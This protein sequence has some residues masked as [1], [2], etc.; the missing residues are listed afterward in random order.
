ML[1]VGAGYMRVL[2]CAWLGC[3]LLNWQLTPCCPP[4]SLWLAQASVI[5]S[6]QV[7]SVHPAAAPSAPLAGRLL[8]PALHGAGA[9]GGGAGGGRGGSPRCVAAGLGPQ[10]VMSR[11][12]CPIV[13]VPACV[14]CL[15]SGAAAV[16][17]RRG[18]TMGRP[19]T[20]AP[21]HPAALAAGGKTTYLAALMRNTAWCLPTR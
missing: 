1:Q 15:A 7:S 13:E 12:C 16:Q 5:G 20:P 3:W 19:V 18:V 4:G 10:L 14:V 9:S 11:R 6:Q 8:L 2:V 17:Q 21:H